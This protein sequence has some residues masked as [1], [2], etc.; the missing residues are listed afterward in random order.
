VQQGRVMFG[1]YAEIN[2]VKL[3][4]SLGKAKDNHSGEWLANF[5][6]HDI[7]AK[8]ISDY[9]GNLQDLSG[10]KTEAQAQSYSRKVKVTPTLK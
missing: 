9:D 3:A 1:V 2:C 6:F 5:T 4:F 7:K 10:H 8:S